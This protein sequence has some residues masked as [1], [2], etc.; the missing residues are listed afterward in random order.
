MALIVIFSCIELK[1]INIMLNRH[2]HIRRNVYIY[3]LDI[4]S[5]FLDIWFMSSCF[6]R[7][8]SIYRDNARI[9]EDKYLLQILMWDEWQGKNAT[10]RYQRWNSVILV[11]YEIILLKM[12]T[13][14]GNCFQNV[15]LSTLHQPA[16][17][18]R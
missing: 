18:F 17:I 1:N 15:E 3:I 5:Y 13:L 10:T 7:M 14:R 9:S 12:L 4:F 16:M 6:L 8:D 11:I 2:H